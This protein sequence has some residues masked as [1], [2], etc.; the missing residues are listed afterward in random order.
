[1][2]VISL[3]FCSCN[4]NP[5]EH[6]DKM[7]MQQD[8]LT[9]KQK[10]HQIDRED[11]LNWENLTDERKAEL[12]NKSKASYD[13][14]KAAKEEKERRKA[15]FEEAMSNWDNLSLDE[16]KAAFD[17][18]DPNATPSK[19]VVKTDTNVYAHDCQHNGKCEGKCNHNGNH[20]C[21]N[22]K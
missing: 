8:S 22:H 4:R 7:Q 17:L 21:P 2:A 3:C 9:D 6:G 19:E 18:L 20:E 1:M 16:R 13:K 10:Q 11:W 15:Q 12:L 14:M 5:K